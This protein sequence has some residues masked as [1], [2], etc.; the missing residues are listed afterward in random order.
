[1]G[2]IRSIIV[3]S[4][5]T[6]GYKPSAA[7][8]GIKTDYERVFAVGTG[9]AIDAEMAVDILSAELTP[10]FRESNLAIKKSWQHIKTSKVSSDFLKAYSAFWEAAQVYP[11][12][13]K[14]RHSGERIPLLHAEEVA[15]ESVTLPF[16]RTISLPINDFVNSLK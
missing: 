8:V 9:G 6:A 14:N 4:K 13:I 3:K 1:M 16:R 12:T 7:P 10:R 15:T 5:R 2:V 11:A